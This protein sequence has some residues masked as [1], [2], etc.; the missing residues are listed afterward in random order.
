MGHFF[1]IRKTFEMAFY[2]QRFLVCP[3]Y[4]LESNRDS[5]LINLQ[6][7]LIQLFFI[8][9]YGKFFVTTVFNS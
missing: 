2:I 3:N 4:F 1:K 5:N 8:I 9:M 7:L 6:K